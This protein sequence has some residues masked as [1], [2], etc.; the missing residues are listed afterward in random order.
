MCLPPL[1]VSA[2]LPAFLTFGLGLLC[3]R[4]A[5]LERWAISGMSGGL[6]FMVRRESRDGVASVGRQNVSER[7]SSNDRLCERP[8]CV[9]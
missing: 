7:T 4:R 8:L 9:Q 5:D 6:G 2:F 1:A 3:R